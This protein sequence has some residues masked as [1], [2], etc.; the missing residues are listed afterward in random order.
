MNSGQNTSYKEKSISIAI[1]G[2][3]FIAISLGCLGSI[4]YLLIAPKQISDIDLSR[5]PFG[6]PIL[7]AYMKQ[8]A[9]FATAILSVTVGFI[10]L[11]I[12]RI[13]GGVVPEQDRQL[14]K[15]ILDKNPENGIEK[16]IELREIS[17]STAFL[18]KMHLSGLPLATIGLTILFTILGLFVPALFDLAKLTAGAF[19]GS[20]VQRQQKNGNGG[21]TDSQASPAQG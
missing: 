17:G 20:Y 2:F 18:N 1:A 15:Q 7:A 21:R 11:R 16:Y 5:H 8:L 10:L 12:S 19:I 14:L 13:Q 9:L 3:C 6:P 4:L